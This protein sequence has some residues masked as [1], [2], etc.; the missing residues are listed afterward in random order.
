VEIDFKNIV[1]E[2]D[3][4]A[5]VQGTIVGVF[6]IVNAQLKKNK[7]NLLFGLFIITYSAELVVALF[8]K[9]GLLNVY[10]RLHFLPL[11]FSFLSLPLF[12]LYVKK[13]SVFNI[14]PTDYRILFPGIIEF[15]FNTLWFIFYSNTDAFIHYFVIYKTIMLVLF[16]LFNF[17]VLKLI[18]ILEKKHERIVCEQYSSTEGLSLKWC[19]NVAVVY[20]AFLLMIPIMIVINRMVSKDNFVFDLVFSLINVLIIYWISIKALEQKIVSSLF[21]LSGNKSEV[22][23][24]PVDVDESLIDEDF[25]NIEIRILDNNLFKIVDLTILSLSKYIDLH[26][27]RISKVINYK[28]N[29]NFNNYI[30]SFRVNEAKNMLTDDQFK[31]LSI[32]GIGYESGFK[33]KSV[34]YKTFKNATGLTPSKF[35]QT[36]LKS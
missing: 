21:P 10:P 31:Y 16:I 18:I 4:I 6:F 35:R 7:Y 30:N 33:S 20:L 1:N 29:G 24:L 34:F 14:K 3:L 8:D 23:E 25:K 26:P 15:I 11:S 32:E 12:Y 19:R 36:N 2:V 9:T 5:F 27:K 17:Y 13:I 28:T 22:S